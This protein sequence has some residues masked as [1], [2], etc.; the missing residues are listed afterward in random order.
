MNK[1]LA[2][3]IS[4]LRFC[5]PSVFLKIIYS[6]TRVL[7]H[8]QPVMNMERC[9]CHKYCF[10][11]WATHKY[12]VCWHFLNILPQFHY[13]HY[14]RMWHNNC[15]PNHVTKNIVLKIFQPSLK[16]T[17]NIN[18]YM[19]SNLCQD[20]SHCDRTLIAVQNC[21]LTPTPANGRRLEK[22]HRTKTENWTFVTVDDEL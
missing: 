18:I 8:Q 2:Q 10:K 5:F 3:Y 16:L 21:L 15:N 13:A 14:G 9:Q 17:P 22:N 7:D 6:L 1:H 11:H 4:V 12:S 20:I 19:L